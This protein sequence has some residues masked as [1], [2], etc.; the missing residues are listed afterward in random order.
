VISTV[1]VPQAVSINPLA[2][3]VAIG[4]SCAAFGGF[5]GSLSTS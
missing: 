5:V 2:V 1:I 4:L 3:I